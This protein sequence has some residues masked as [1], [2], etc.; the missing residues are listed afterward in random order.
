MPGSYTVAA[1]INTVVNN[2]VGYMTDQQQ[3]GVPEYWVPANIGGNG[4]CEDYALAK[5]RMLMD[6]GWARSDACLLTCFDGPDGHCVLLVNTDAGWRIL[7]NK[8]PDLRK[9]SECPYRWAL[10]LRNGRWWYAGFVWN[11]PV[12]L[13]PAAAPAGWV[14]YVARNPNDPD[15]SR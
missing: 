15:A 2:S 3:Y 10:I 6:V 4:D 7:D 5:R 14:G 13:I 11:R 12:T 9:A 1:G 8:S